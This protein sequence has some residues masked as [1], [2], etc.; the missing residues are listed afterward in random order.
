[1]EDLR[2]LC[3]TTRLR[4]CFYPSWSHYCGGLIDTY[5]AGRYPSIRAAA[6]ANSVNCMTLTRRLNGGLSIA[7]SREPT[8]LL[9]NE[10]EEMIKRWIIELET[11][12]HA[13]TFN[14]VWKL[15]VI[16]SEATNG[17]NTIDTTLL[18]RH[19]ELRSKVGK[20]I[21]VHSMD[22]SEAHLII[23]FCVF[24]GISQC[25]YDCLELKSP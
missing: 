7:Q 1:L 11:M 9:T 2:I 22:A 16:V 25:P 14:A 18:K 23:D 4:F 15:A 6:A 10:Q 21:H 3:M 20:K 17:S 24:Y 5:Q 8:Q 13:P 19:P 12:G